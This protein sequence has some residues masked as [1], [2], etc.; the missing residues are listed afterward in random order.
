MAVA[1]RQES[2]KFLG[3]TLAQGMGDLVVDIT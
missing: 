2:A 3:A 1:G